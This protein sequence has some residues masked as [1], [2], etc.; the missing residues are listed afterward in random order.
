[1]DPRKGGLGVSLIRRSE[2]LGERCVK[3]S[4]DEEERSDVTDT[5]GTR[6]LVPRRE[7][8]RL[9]SRYNDSLIIKKV[10]VETIKW[11]IGP[12][13]S[14]QRVHSYLRPDCDPEKL[15]TTRKLMF[16]VGGRLL[17]RP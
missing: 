14:L 12:Q 4:F 5:E 13:K 8:R 1:M 15:Q 6:F 9:V 17:G 11:S 7:R 10:H 3:D 2:Q 16:V